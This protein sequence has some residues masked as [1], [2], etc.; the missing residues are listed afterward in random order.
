MWLVAMRR[1]YVNKS[2]LLQIYFETPIWETQE[3]CW[4]AAKGKISIQECGNVPIR[5]GHVQHNFPS[6]DP[7]T[8]SLLKEKKMD[9][10]TVGTWAK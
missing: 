7:F 4:P 1:Q 9:F 6:V 5:S 2:L 10:R 3:S 8:V